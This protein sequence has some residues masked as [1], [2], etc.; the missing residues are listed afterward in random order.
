VKRSTAINSEKILSTSRTSPPSSTQTKFVADNRPF[1]DP[2][3][4]ARKLLCDLMSGTGRQP[5]N[6]VRVEAFMQYR[7]T[8]Y[9]IVQT[10]DPAGWKW[11]VQLDQNRS[12]TGSST[13]RATAV[14][15]AQR[16]IDKALKKPE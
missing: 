15:L 14:A 8:E 16:A 12:R 5:L 11:T 9:Q 2:E 6:A 13:R 10:A 4:A 1:T 3:A 7:N